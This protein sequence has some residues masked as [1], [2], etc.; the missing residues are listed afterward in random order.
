M[1]IVCWFGYIFLFCSFPVFAQEFA[2]MG[3]IWHYDYG[4][5]YR[6]IKPIKDTI[7]EG[8]NSRIIEIEDT[9]N[10]TKEIIA[11]EGNRILHYKDGAFYTLFDFDAVPGD[12]WIVKNNTAWGDCDSS[13]TIMVDSIGTII[14]NGI[15]LKYL[16]LSFSLNS[17]WRFGTKTT[18]KVIERIGPLG[19]FFPDL[20]CIS[21]LPW[22]RDLRCYNDSVFGFFDTGIAASCT[23][24]YPGVGQVEITSSKDFSLTYPN[25]FSKYINF[26][27]EGLNKELT[28]E[29]IE[30]ATGRV[31]FSD[32]FNASF[33]SVC[34]ERIAPGMYI[35]R[36]KEKDTIISSQKVIC[37]NQNQ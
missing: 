37:A 24:K 8:K 12:S 9:F 3:A 34:T 1:K 28:F 7:V 17:N 35:T 5:W 36:V 23:T 18:I 20:E 2:P 31:I 26:K 25:P 29:I 19:Y 6:T 27:L 33:F 22:L 32:K 4:N 11:T 14:I 21:D 10:T 16:I 30:I 13:E 15:S